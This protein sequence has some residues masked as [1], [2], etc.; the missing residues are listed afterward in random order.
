LFEI[1][2]DRIV[3]EGQPLLPS[4]SS[5]FRKEMG[6]KHSRL[7]RKGYSSN[8]RNYGNEL[9]KIAIVGPNGTGKSS[10]CIQFVCNYF[11]E[12]YD[13]TMEVISSFLYIRF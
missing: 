5:P 6:I 3:E 8:T 10:I 1:G 7:A 11:P 13:P 12:E 2:K 4:Q 9:F